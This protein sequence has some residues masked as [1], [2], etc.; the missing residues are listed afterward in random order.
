MDYHGSLLGDRFFFFPFLHITRK[1]MKGA[2]LLLLSWVSCTT[3]SIL[4]KDFLRLFS[5]FYLESL[6]NY[7]FIDKEESQIQKDYFMQLVVPSCQEEVNQCPGDISFDKLVVAVL[8]A[9]VLQSLL[10]SPRRDSGGSTTNNSASYYP[11]NDT[12]T[13]ATV[14]GHP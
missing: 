9:L 8:P 14:V 13:A 3:F 5:T 7:V 10:A 4:F 11:N 6:G 12:S 1:Q 2:L